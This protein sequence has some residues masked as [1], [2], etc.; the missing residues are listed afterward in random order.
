[1]YIKNCSGVLIFN[2][3]IKDIKNKTKQT[4]EIKRESNISTRLITDI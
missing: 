2:Y 4:Y 3:L 1:M